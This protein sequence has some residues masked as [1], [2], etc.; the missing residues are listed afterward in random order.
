MSELS[1][2]IDGLSAHIQLLWEYVAE[3]HYDPR[4]I[5]G[6]RC[7]DM[8]EL[9]R[10]RINGMLPE[11]ETRVELAA[12]L[13]YLSVSM[14]AIRSAVDRN[15][16]DDRLSEWTNEAE[17]IFSKIKECMTDDQKRMMKREGGRIRGQA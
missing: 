17:K 7:L 10:D 12:Q 15:L 5:V 2:A 9:M 13:G 8:Y 1:D 11:Y 3:G 16:F 4:S 6:D 14:R